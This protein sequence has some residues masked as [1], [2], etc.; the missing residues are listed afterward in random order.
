[1]ERQYLPGIA[2]MAL[3][4][5][6]SNVL[7]QFLYGQWLTYGAFVYPFA[8]L[9]TDLMNRLYGAA[10]ARRVVF[11]GFAV[12]VL[13]SLIGTQWMIEF[14]PGVEGPAVTLRIAIASGTAFLCAQLIDVQ[15]FET[16]RQGTWWRA[17]FVSTVVGA[18]V[19]TA[20]FFSIAFSTALNGIEPAAVPDW[21]QSEIPIFHIGPLAPLWVSLALADWCVKLTLAVLSLVPFRLIV[22]RVVSRKPG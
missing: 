6:A 13:C 12:G 20:L 1:M 17:P 16:L 14:E 7:V 21:A 11:L 22:G 4:V 5:L 18:S 8:F 2:A 9:V 3:I 15:L 10:V 19:D